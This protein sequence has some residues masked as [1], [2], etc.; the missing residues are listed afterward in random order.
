MNKVAVYE[1]LL[2]NH[3]LWEKVAIS[4]A[5][6][7][8]AIASRVARVAQM[9]KGPV[10]QAMAQRSANQLGRIGSQQFGQQHALAGRAVDAVNRGA[11]GSAIANATALSNRSANAQKL[12]SSAESGQRHFLGVANPSMRARLAR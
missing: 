2:E 7:N 3:P 4:P 6:L 12:V 1:A 5:L 10:Q 11:S 8:K 9:P